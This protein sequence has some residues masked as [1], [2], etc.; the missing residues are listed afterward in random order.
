MNKRRSVDALQTGDKLVREEQ[1]RLE[2][3]LALTKDEEL[4]QT[5]TNDVE[6]H[7]VVYTVGAIPADNGNADTA[8]EGLVDASLIFKLGPFDFNVF[9]LDG[10]LLAGDIMRTEVYLTKEPESKF[11]ADAVPA[12]AV[13]AAAQFLLNPSAWN[14]SFWSPTYA[15][16]RSI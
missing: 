1:H 7:G 2:R 14:T 13:L 3:E 4:L 10:N 11:A 15:P 9:K 8:A 5:G 6:D 16:A 12:D